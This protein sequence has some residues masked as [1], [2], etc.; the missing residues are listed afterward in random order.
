MAKQSEAKSMA[1]DYDRRISSA[2][3]ALPTCTLGIGIGWGGSTGGS[4]RL[5]QLQ[6]QLACVL[7][8]PPSSGCEGSDASEATA[9]TSDPCLALPCRSQAS[10]G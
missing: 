3:H 6:R 4:V 8:R 10:L 1:H 2:A 9:T 7:L 5:V